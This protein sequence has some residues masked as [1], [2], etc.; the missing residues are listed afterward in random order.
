MVFPIDL[1]QQRPGG[2]VLHAQNEAPECPQMQM[3]DA[4]AARRMMSPIPFEKFP[5]FP[6][7][8]R[9]PS[10]HFGL[11]RLVYANG[12]GDVLLPASILL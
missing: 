4:V 11:V 2:C 9:E 10:T 3:L 5:I 6:F 1:F 12:G 8:H 7:I